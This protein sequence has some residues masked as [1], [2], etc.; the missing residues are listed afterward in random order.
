MLQTAQKSVSLQQIRFRSKIN[1]QRPKPFHHERGKVMEFLT[2]FYANPDK[3]KKLWE[4]CLKG[5]KKEG[6]KSIANPYQIIIAREILNWFNNS[7]MVG[8]FHLN[9][10]KA[11]ENFNFQVNLKKHNMYAKVYGRRL[12]ELAVKDTVY[13]PV[14]T[15]FSSPV[16]LVFSPDTHVN[17]LVKTA[18]KTPEVILMGKILI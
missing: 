5:K 15:L 13:E 10:I 6:N 4:V 1:I 11:E 7:K 17:A 12:M 8:F 9:S 18:K 3:G 2:P 16:L 14:L